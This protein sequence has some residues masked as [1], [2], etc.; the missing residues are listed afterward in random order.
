MSVTAIIPLKALGE[1]KGRLADALGAPE[2]R[3]LVGWMVRRVI[4]ACQGCD[5][6]TDILVVAGDQEGAAVATAAGARSVVVDQA[7][8]AVALQRADTLTAAADA[9][10]VVAADLPTV[11][12]EDL[13]AVIQAAAPGGRAVVVAPTED[14]G[15]GALLRRPPGVIGTAY[16][17]GSAARHAQLA[18]AA[19]VEAAVVRR[20][21][22]AWDVDTPAQL[23]AALALAAEHD[24][25]CA[26]R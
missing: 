15:T 2:R 4:A 10:V 22:L 12:A 25:G 5:L 24:V 3:A 13:A 16:G 17:L 20:P 7:G 8:L 23:P 21:G 6:V 11:T 1:A 14:G 26:P 19:G 9:T 18:A